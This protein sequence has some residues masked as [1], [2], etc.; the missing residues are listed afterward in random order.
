MNEWQVTVIYYVVFL[1]IIFLDAIG[2]ALYDEQM[3]T[4]SGVL[5]TILLVFFVT[6]MCLVGTN[7]LLR[8][9][10]YGGFVWLMTGYVCLRYALFDYVYNITRGLHPFYTGSTKLLDSFWRWWFRK[11]KIP[12]MLW[13]IVTRLMAFVLGL[14]AISRGIV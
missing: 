6:C 5:Q 1:V 11:T 14:H 7:T 12:A 9:V 3:K 8:P 13:F 4:I 2:D 10:T